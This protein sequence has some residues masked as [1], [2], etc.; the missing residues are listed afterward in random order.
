MLLTIG[1]CPPS[2][3]IGMPSAHSSP[4]AASPSL[5]VIDTRERDVDGTTVCGAEY[6]DTIVSVLHVRSTEVFVRH[7]ARFGVSDIRDRHEDI[8]ASIVELTAVSS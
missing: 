4:S 3:R 5:C 2:I 1:E 6:E 8:V 7:Y